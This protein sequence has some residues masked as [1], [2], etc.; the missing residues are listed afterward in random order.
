[1]DQKGD[2]DAC[3]TVRGQNG[4]KV[5]TAVCNHFLLL[6]NR[7]QGR[8]SHTKI[9]ATTATMKNDQDPATTNLWTV[10]SALLKKSR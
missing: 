8:Q 4:A 9:W 5:V 10:Q 3:E 2:D 1:M 6:L 7:Y